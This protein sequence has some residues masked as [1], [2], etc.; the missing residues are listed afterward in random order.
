MWCN[1]L[2]NEYGYHEDV[3]VDYY[4]CNNIHNTHTIKNVVGQPDAILRQVWGLFLWTPLMQR[5][6]Q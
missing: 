1:E 4:A 5:V 6:G 3:S 2:V